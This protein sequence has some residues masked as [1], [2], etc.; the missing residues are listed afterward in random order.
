[1]KV[2]D[3]GQSALASLLKCFRTKKIYIRSSI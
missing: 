3:T 2:K 1:M